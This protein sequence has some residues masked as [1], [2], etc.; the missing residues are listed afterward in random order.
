MD[1]DEETRKGSIITR[2]ASILCMDWFS[3]T[4]ELYKGIRKLLKHSLPEG[5]YEV[6][7]YDSVLELLDSKGEMALFKKRHK[8]KFLQDNVIAYQ[9]YAWGDGD[10]Q[11][12]YKCSPGLVVDRYREGDRWNMLISLRETKSNGDIQEFH[13]ERKIRNGFTKREEWWQIAMQHQTKWLK[14]SVIFPKRRRCQN[15]I[16][17]ERNTNR[18]VRLGPTYFTD[19]TDGRQMLTW[20]NKKPRRFEIYTFKWLW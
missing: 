20:E 18:S 4:L 17:I 13:I 3:V 9:D 1:S 5:L 11:V 10:V 7:E 6:L 15:A 16:L 14:L 12:D 19:L 2:I 8:V